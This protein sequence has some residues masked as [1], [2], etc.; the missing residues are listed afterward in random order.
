VD[1][2]ADQGR[3]LGLIGPNGSGKTTLLRMLYGALAPRSGRVE[4]D[5]VSLSD[6]SVRDTARRLAAVVQETGG[7]STLTSTEMVMLGRGPHLSTFQRFGTEAHRIV[8]DAL[9]TVGGLGLGARPFSALSG[10]EKQR[11]LIARALAQS[12][13]HMLLDEPTNHL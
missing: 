6:L 7:E 11:V 3:V 9:A 10:G 12:A 1:L 8:R 4:V 13:D 2:V 5:G